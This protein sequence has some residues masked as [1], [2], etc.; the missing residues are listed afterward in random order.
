MILSVTLTDT[1]ERIGTFTL[2]R[3]QA[4]APVKCL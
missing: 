4:G 3:G 2:V 1:G